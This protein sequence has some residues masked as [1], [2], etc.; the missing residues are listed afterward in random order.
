M[1]DIDKIIG[2]IIDNDLPKVER[3]VDKNNIDEFN[4]EFISPLIMAA[5]LKRYYI[6][7]YLIEARS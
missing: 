5:R 1:S 6:V 7:K 4:Y 2:A 3:L